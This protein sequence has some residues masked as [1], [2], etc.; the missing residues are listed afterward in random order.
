MNQYTYHPEVFG[1]EKGTECK[2][3]LPSSFNAQHCGKYSNVHNT[4][5]LGSEIQSLSSASCLV[6]FAQV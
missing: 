5:V 1:F 4:V 3:T 6:M 2:D